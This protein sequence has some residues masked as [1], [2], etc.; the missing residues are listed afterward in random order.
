MGVVRFGQPPTR[1]R[2]HTHPRT[3]GRMMVI[4]TLKQHFANWLEFWV[5]EKKISCDAVDRFLKKINDVSI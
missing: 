1:T 4:L 5:Y 2:T 3:H